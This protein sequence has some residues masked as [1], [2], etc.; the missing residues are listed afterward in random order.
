MQE[1]ILDFPLAY[2][3]ITAVLMKEGRKVKQS[4][5]CDYEAERASKTQYCWLFRCKNKR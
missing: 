1:I 2:S 5:P 3:V 4:R